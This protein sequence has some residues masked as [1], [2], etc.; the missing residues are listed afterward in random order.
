MLVLH[1]PE[2]L[3]IVEYGLNKWPVKNAI[4]IHFLKVREGE[5]KI[6]CFFNNL[7]YNS[8]EETDILTL[9]QQ[10]THAYKS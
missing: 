7:K 2:I 1:R 5:P 6:L 9:K 10:E 4:Y 8:I 3:G